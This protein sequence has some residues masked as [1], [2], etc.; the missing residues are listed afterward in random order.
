MFD[1]KEI[2]ITNLTDV[3]FEELCFDLLFELGFDELQWRRGGAD[4]GRDIEG[5]KYFDSPLIGKY[6]EK[7]FFECKRYTKGVP[8]DQLNSKIAWADAEKPKHLVF[9]I[10]SYLTSGARTWLEKLEND[11]FYKIHTI[12]EKQLKKLVLSKPRLIREYFSSDLQK[13][14]RDSIRS[15]V[16]HNIVPEPQLIRTL[17]ES[18]EADQFSIEELAFLWNAAKYRF[19]E[20]ALNMEDSFEA[21]IDWMFRLLA[22]NANVNMPVL[23]ISDSLCLL[24]EREGSSSFDLVYNKIYS[25]E[26][27]FLVEGS[28]TIALYS[29]VRDNDGE[30]IEVLVEQNSSLTCYIRHIPSNAKV[31]LFNVKKT[32]GNT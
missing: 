30:G 22:N 23:N 29:F 5:I 6:K 12:E 10:S 14:M 18:E 16:L 31:E 21:S 25:A 8:P 9:F 20:V 19:E 11:K 13:L 3:E 24:D 2:V 7:W 28:E 32:L 26:V 17:S 4:N 1:E 15:W 27:A